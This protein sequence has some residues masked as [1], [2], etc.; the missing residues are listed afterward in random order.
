MTTIHLPRSDLAR[1]LGIFAV[2]TE[3][4]LPA[5]WGPNARSDGPKTVMVSVP[6]LAFL[7]GDLSAGRRGEA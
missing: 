7:H 4:M 6:Y 5:G 3:R 2:E 1:E